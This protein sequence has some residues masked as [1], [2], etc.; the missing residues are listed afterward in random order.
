MTIPTSN[1]TTEGALSGALTF[2][3]E[4]YFHVHAFSSVIDRKDWPN[5]E[6]RVEANTDRLLALLDDHGTKAT[7][8]TLGC[9]AR[10]YPAIIR[11]IVEGGHE[12]ASHGWDHYAV[13]DQG[14]TT[15]LEDIRRTRLFLEDTGGVAVRG[16]RAPSFSIN[17][18]TPWAYEALA[19][20]GYTYSSSSHPIQHDHYG[21][22]DS[23]RYPYREETAKLLEIPITTTLWRGKRYPLGG[24]GF[25]RLL[26]L[27]LAMLNAERMRAE[28]VPPNFY[29]HPWEI[30]PEQ[31]RIKA[32]PLKSRF[33][34]TV[35]LSRC[36]A[37]LRKLV[38][39]APWTRMDEAYHGWLNALSVTNDTD[40]QRITA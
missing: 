36:E 34:H 21:N 23:P 22:P 10:D 1:Q 20:A 6:S 17:A 4:D 8:F 16:Y 9:V 2:D 14:R 35:G 15:F 30:D 5:F 12:L 32:A 24:G 31:P 29:L 11:R 39:G 7:F 28:G 33:R 40:G 27:K 25:F 13:S 3:V 26:P 18:Q 38:A 19:E 37:K